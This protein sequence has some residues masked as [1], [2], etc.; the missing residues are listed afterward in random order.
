MDMRR[1]TLKI[2]LRPTNAVGQTVAK[3][4]N[5]GLVN[6]PLQTIFSQVTCSL[7]QTCVKRTGTNY[8]YKAYINTLLE[9]GANDSVMGLA[10]LREGRHNGTD[11]RNG[12]NTCLYIR[13]R[14]TDECRLLELEGPP[15]PGHV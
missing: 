1:S 14:Y 7:Q 6:L 9:T 15:S 4:A 5:T 3:N 10:T 11:V 8:L 2:K 12:V 13:S